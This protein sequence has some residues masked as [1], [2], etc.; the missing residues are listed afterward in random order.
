MLSIDHTSVAADLL[1]EGINTAQPSYVIV[2]TTADI[3]RMVTEVSGHVYPG[4]LN[5]AAPLVD[6]WLLQLQQQIAAQRS[7]DDSWA[8]H[9]H[10]RPSE[11][12]LAA[13]EVLGSLFAEVPAPLRPQYS[14]DA[15]G[16]PTYTAYDDRIYLHLTIDESGLLS[17]Y[18]VVNDVEMF[19]EEVDVLGSANNLVNRIL[20]I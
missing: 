10:Q 5:H 4:P 20:S 8:E 2:L 6:P 9:Y 18:S 16:N 19:E 11:D 14:L 3:P 12:A 13:A 7:M 15:D 17:W 1:F